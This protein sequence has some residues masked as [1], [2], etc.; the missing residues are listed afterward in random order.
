[1]YDEI[2][3]PKTAYLTHADYADICIGQPYGDRNP[4]THKTHTRAHTHDAQKTH[5]RRTEDAHAHTDTST[6]QS[7]NVIDRWVTHG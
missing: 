5:R 2:L 4:H 1:M 3:Y 7:L 6:N